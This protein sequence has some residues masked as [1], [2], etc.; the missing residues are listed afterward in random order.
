MTKFKTRLIDRLSFLSKVRGLIE[1]E[2]ASLPDGKIYVRRYKGNIS[3]Y[4]RINKK[5]KYLAKKNSSK[6]ICQLAQKEYCISMIKLIDTEIKA[7]R[8]YLDNCPSV[9]LEDFRQVVDPALIQ[10]VLPIVES[11]EAYLKK[12]EE[13]EYDRLEYHNYYDEKP[14][15]FNG[16]RSKS[17]LIIANK[18]SKAGIKFKYEK[19]LRVDGIE[20]YPD[21]TLLDVVNRRELYW[22]HF[23]MMDDEVYVARTMKKINLYNKAGLIQ[24]GQMIITMESGSAPIDMEQVDSVIKELEKKCCLRS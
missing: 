6:K 24:S 4:Q 3:F 22:E 18:L 5:E 7:T 11:D 19:L 20:M 10:F 1:K 8:Y 12:W 21:F 16:F 23:G 17:E 15:E 9:E 13:A 2:Y 14:V